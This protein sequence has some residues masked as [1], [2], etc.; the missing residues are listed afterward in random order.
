MW[1]GVCVA[2][3][4]DWHGWRSSP[5]VAVMRSRCGGGANVMK[6]DNVEV[7]KILW[8]DGR[9]KKFGGQSWWSKSLLVI[10]FSG[11]GGVVTGMEE[12]VIMVVMVGATGSS[13][14]SVA[15]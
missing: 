11:C 5:S 7:G 1:H 10:T 3:F 12:D 14:G 4:N 9:L 15:V 13:V 8:D 6:E 2:D